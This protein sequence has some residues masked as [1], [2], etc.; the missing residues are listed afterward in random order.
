MLNETFSVIFKHRARLRKRQK[1]VVLK[2]TFLLM[3]FLLIL[4]IGNWSAQ[5]STFVTNQLWRIS[6]EHHFCGL[7]WPRS[8]GP[9]RDIGHADFGRWNETRWATICRQ[10]H[11][12]SR[13]CWTCISTQSHTL[14]IFLHFIPIVNCWVLSL[15]EEMILRL[16]F[17]EFGFIRQAKIQ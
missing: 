4:G 11:W 9:L 17:H 2:T 14:R 12:S 5:Q 1:T 7:W 8:T 13:V 15:I 10:R 3:Y 6:W 16:Y